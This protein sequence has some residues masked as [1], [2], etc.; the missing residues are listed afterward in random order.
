MYL[1]QKNKQ[2]FPTRRKQTELLSVYVPWAVSCGLRAQF[3]MNVFFEKHFE[4]PIDLLR[5]KLGIAAP[6]DGTLTTKMDV[7]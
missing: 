2:S 5:E 6:P 3:L 1:T 7:K 4:E